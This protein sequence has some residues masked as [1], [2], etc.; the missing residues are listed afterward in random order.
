MDAL[1]IA[2]ETEGTF[3]G[4][5]RVRQQLAACAAWPPPNPVPIPFAAGRL[6]G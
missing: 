4:D 2:R 6:T 3:L 1:A 5:D